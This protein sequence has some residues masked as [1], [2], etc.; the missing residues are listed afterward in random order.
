MPLLTVYVDRT[1]IHSLQDG[2]NFKLHSSQGKPLDELRKPVCSF[3]TYTLISHEIVGT[4]V[5]VGS[6]VE[7]ISK[8]DRVGVGAQIGSCLSCKY[9]KSGNENYCP[10]GIDTYVSA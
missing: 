2:V 1:S 5:R 6:K 3:H 8:G 7:G 10:K 4:A 9:C